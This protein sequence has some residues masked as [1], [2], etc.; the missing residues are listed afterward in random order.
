MYRLWADDV[1][2]DDEFRSLQEGDHTMELLIKQVAAEDFGSFYCHAENV[3]GGMTKLVTLT[4]QKVSW[5]NSLL[6]FRR[7]LHTFPFTW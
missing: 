1:D 3:F 6:L 7:H 5:N 2:A 4:K